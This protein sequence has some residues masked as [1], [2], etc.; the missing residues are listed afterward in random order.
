MTDN[1]TE[2]FEQVNKAQDHIVFALQ[3]LD[4]RRS[5]EASG[6]IRGQLDLVFIQLKYLLEDSLPNEDW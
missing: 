6:F 1:T 2:V 5:K 3:E 4:K